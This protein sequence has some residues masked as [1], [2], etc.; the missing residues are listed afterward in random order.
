MALGST[1]RWAIGLTAAALLA[2]AGAASAA[3]SGVQ[4]LP[5]EDE[6]RV[7]ILVDGKPFTSYIYRDTLKKP[8]LYPLL[9]EGGKPVTRG[10]PIDPR[11]GERVD[12][13]HHVGLWFNHGDVNGV[14]FWNN[15]GG[16]GSSKMG[17][18]VHRAIQNARGG[19]SQADLDVLLEWLMPDG[20]PVLKEETRF[21][22]LAQPKLRIVDRAAKLTALAE[23]VVFKDNKEGVLGL[24]VARALEHPSTKPEVFT[25]AK[26]KPTTVAR[27]DNTGV[28]GRYLT[29]EGKTGEEVWGTRGRWCALQGRVDG[30]DVTLAIFDHPRN[31]GHPT[32]WH[33]RGYGL[34]AANPLGQK[35]FS[36]GAA[37]LNLTLEPGEW[38]VFRYRIVILSE[39]VKKERIEA[40]YDDFLKGR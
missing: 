38:V 8:V 26:G 9:T 24:R 17:T 39:A 27:L 4:I 34:F 19:S 36:N 22:F 16:E 10:F 1:G 15:S 21:T 20:H 33:A 7:D 23:R 11:P 40:L 25:D 37:E 2:A 28:T 31:P 5:R 13:P 30:K 18:I 29:S 6:R 12:H 32:Y 14:D 3:S 35:V